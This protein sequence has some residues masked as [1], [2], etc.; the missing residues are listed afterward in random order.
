MISQ[1]NIYAMDIVWILCDLYVWRSKF[2][3]GRYG[4]FREILN[5]SQHNK[6]SGVMWRKYGKQNIEDCQLNKSV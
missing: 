1:V 4:K 3:R 6:F 2:N 5:I